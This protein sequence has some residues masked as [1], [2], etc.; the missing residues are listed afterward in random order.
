[1]SKEKFEPPIQEIETPEVDT[2]IS[3]TARYEEAHRDKETKVD[4]AL[5]EK[6]RQEIIEHY[7]IDLEHVI[8]IPAPVGLKREM[9]AF[10]IL[11]HKKDPEKTYYAD[12]HEAH[13]N[14]LNE[15]LRKF[16]EIGVADRSL[17][18]KIE[19]DF[20]E[21]WEVKKGSIDPYRKGFED[22]ESIHTSLRELVLNNQHENGLTREQEEKLE[23]HPDARLPNWFVIGRYRGV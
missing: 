12:G 14:L 2:N 17:I 19:D 6:T 20:Y 22:F 10:T 4:E 23:K 7:N 15:I 3:G 11:R 21:E 9:R 8:S 18:K 16:S 5:A 1:M 13:A